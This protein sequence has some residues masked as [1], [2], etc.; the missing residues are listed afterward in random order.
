LQPVDR[1]RLFQCVHNIGIHAIAL[2]S[3]DRASEKLNN[4]N[5]CEF[6]RK[7]V[8][9]FAAWAERIVPSSCT[10]GCERQVDRD[11][12]CK[13]SADAVPVGLSAVSRQ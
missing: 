6:I 10:A 5:M 12:A 9:T 7:F 2:G 4:D 8:E 13:N 11:C 3:L 1:K